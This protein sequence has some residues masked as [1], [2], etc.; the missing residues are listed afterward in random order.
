[1][2]PNEVRKLGR[3]L[4]RERLGLAP[5]APISDY[6][7]AQT[8]HEDMGVSHRAVMAWLS[9]EYPPS[10]TSAKLLTALARPQRR[11]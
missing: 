7:I 3:I 11:E 6:R 5:N 8:I 4:T 10:N 2:T 1:M 9:G